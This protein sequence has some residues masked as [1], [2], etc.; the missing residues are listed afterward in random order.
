MS[1]ALI[2]NPCAGGGRA[3]RTL[4]G[5]EAALRERQLDYRVERTRSL[6]HAREL[7]RAA[8]LGGMSGGAA[9]GGGGRPAR[10]PSGHLRR[11]SRGPRSR[12]RPPLPVNGAAATAPPGRLLDQLVTRCAWDPTRAAGHRLADDAGRTPQGAFA[13]E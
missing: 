10:R 8:A 4:P 1:L 2:V 13:S 3:G 7:A 11:R 12:P 6:D 5:V 9:G